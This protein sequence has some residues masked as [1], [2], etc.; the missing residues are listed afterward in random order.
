MTDKIGWAVVG[1]P[2]GSGSDAVITTFTG[3]ALPLPEAELVVVKVAPGGCIE[4]KTFADEV[5][6]A[7]SLN[8][9]GGCGWVKLRGGCRGV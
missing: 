9:C 8:S 2:V 5:E 6:A 3:A 7:V 4:A 1:F